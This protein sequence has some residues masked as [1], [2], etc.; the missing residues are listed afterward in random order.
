LHSRSTSERTEAVR[1][2]GKEVYLVGHKECDYHLHRGGMHQSTHGITDYYKIGVAENP[3]Q[4][5]SAMSTGT[6]HKLELI[7]TVA[8]DDAKKAERYLHRY[9][10][11]WRIK[12]EWFKLLINAVNSLRA[13]EFISSETVKEVCYEC[14]KGNL[15]WRNTLYVHLHRMSSERPGKEVYA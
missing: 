11:H 13:L 9:Y 3:E 7:T 8:A 10:Q 1:M 12:G 4:R 6:P 5:L 2:S 15:D 14:L